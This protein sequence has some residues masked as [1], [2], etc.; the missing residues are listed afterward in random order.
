MKLDNAEEISKT[1]KQTTIPD[2][3]LPAQIGKKIYLAGPFF[4][5]RQKALVAAVTKKLRAQGHDVFVPME[6]EV[7]DVWSLPN[8]TWSNKVFKSDVAAIKSANEVWA[9]TFGMN[10]DAGTCWEV[11]FAYGIGKPI[12]LLT[13]NPSKV[14]SLMIYQSCNRVVDLNLQDKKREDIEQS[15]VE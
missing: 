7:E 9:F 8:N 1:D 4:N 3:K 5:K 11:G 13:T 2:I 10:D 12:T 15:S 6:H 14:H